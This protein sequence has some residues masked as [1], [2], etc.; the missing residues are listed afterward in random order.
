MRAELSPTP[1][2]LASTSLMPVQGEAHLIRQVELDVAIDTGWRQGA[3]FLAGGP[4]IGTAG[5]RQGSA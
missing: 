1:S 2:T 5:D 4:Y 3:R